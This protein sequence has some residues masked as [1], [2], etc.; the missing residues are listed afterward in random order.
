[1][2]NAVHILQAQQ[3]VHGTVAPTPAPPLSADKFNSRL[4]NGR[5]NNIPWRQRKCYHLH[6]DWNSINVFSFNCK[7]MSFVA[8][9]PW[10]S[11]LKENSEVCDVVAPHFVEGQLLCFWLITSWCIALFRAELFNIFYTRFRRCWLKPSSKKRT[12]KSC[13]TC[14]TISS[15]YRFQTKCISLLPGSFSNHHFDWEI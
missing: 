4:V 15:E 1:M 8:S 12:Y 13:E 11:W 2:Y 9:Y 3:Q 14:G 5:F 10:W 6:P 7:P